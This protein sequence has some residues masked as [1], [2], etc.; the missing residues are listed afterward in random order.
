MLLG[1]QQS[2]TATAMVRTLLVGAFPMSTLLNSNLKGGKSRRPTDADQPSH[3]KLDPEIME[4]I[5]CEY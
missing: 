1:A 4:A 3:E 5:Y 2:T